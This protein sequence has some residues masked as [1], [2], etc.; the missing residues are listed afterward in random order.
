MVSGPSIAWLVSRFPAHN[1][2]FMLR[3]ME[4]MRELGFDVHPIALGDPDRPPEQLTP[5]EREAFAHTWYLRRQGSGAIA[6]AHARVL[7]HSPA[8][9]LRGLAAAM[10]F[11]GWE[12]PRVPANL[13]YFAGAVVIG[14]HLNRLGIRWLHSHYTS[15]V[16]Y[17][18]DVIFAPRLAYSMTIHGSG[19]FEDVRGFRLADKIRRAKLVVAISSFGRSQMMKITKPAEWPKLQVVRLGIDPT[20]Y[21][22]A[23]PDPAAPFTVVAAGMLVSVKGYP[24][25]LDAIAALRAEGRS[26]RLKLAGDGTDRQELEQQARRL[27][28]SP[29]V[30]SFLGWIDASRLPEVYRSAN[31]VVISSFAEGIPVVLMEA[32]AMGIPCVAPYIGGIAELIENQVSG[33]LVPAG[34]TEALAAALRTLMDSPALRE[35]IATAGRN[36]VANRYCLDSN[37]YEL[38]KALWKCFPNADNKVSLQ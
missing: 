33:L 37:S 5:R 28:L 32:M 36:V 2:A 6:M 29:D 30:V 7:L 17:L 21:P 23:A 34:D 20:Q 11:S 8:G 1:H 31:A 24:L 27:G 18:I 19:E 9:W 35:S 4:R 25:L 12:W 3:E 13:K 15:T 22:S 38:A 10:T 16:A 14:D 26:I